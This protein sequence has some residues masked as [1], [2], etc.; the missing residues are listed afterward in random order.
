MFNNTTQPYIQTT[1]MPYTMLRPTIITTII[2]TEMEEKQTIHYYNEIIITIMK[3]IGLNTITYCTDKQYQ[4]IT[5]QEEE[6][7][8]IYIIPNIQL[9]KHLIK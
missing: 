5:L 6:N 2:S 3:V 8:L 9:I 7:M 4:L 1:T